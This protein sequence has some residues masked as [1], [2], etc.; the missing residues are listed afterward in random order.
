MSDYETYIEGLGQTIPVNRIG[1]EEAAML[2]EY[3][4]EMCDQRVTSGRLIELLAGLRHE[5]KNRHGDDV[6]S[7]VLNA[8]AMWEDANDREHE[9][10]AY[11]L[12]ANEPHPWNHD[13][14]AE[15]EGLR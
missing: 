7:D 13:T 11:E 8:L 10:R 2:L 12:D 9:R 1:L 3:V 15:K 5:W 6:V 14:H 4:Q